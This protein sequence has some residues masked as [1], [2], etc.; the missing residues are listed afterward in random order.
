[1]E[2]SADSYVRGRIILIERAVQ[3]LLP[4]DQ[5]R[6]FGVP[7]DIEGARSTMWMSLVTYVLHV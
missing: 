1:M 2:F 7:S 3:W 5:R 4:R 6:G